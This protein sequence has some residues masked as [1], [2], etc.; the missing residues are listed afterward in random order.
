VQ[1]L[2]DTVELVREDGGTEVRMRRRRR[3]G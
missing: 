3:E 1:A 2:M